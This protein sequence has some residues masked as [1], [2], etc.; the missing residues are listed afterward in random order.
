MS[1]F[2]FPNNTKEY[3]KW[4]YLIYKILIPQNNAIAIVNKKAVN[5]TVPFENELVPL[6]SRIAYDHASHQLLT[7]SSEGGA[8][9][10]GPENWRRPTINIYNTRKMQDLNIKV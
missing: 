2:R 6:N 1:V 4:E 8:D 9:F 10:A 5:R 7:S 3:K